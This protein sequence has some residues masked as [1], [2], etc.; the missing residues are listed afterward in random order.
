MQDACEST[1]RIILNGTVHDS[2][3]YRATRHSRYRTLHFPKGR[4]L[5]VTVQQLID[6]LDAIRI[7]APYWQRWETV[8]RIEALQDK[9]EQE[10]VK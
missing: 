1:I 7:Q 2:R 4:W 10:G 8:S 3:R 5:K 9:I 6:E